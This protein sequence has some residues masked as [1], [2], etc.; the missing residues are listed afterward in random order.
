[1]IKEIYANIHNLVIL[2][3]RLFGHIL[4]LF[5]QKAELE[6][7]VSVLLS[8]YGGTTQGAGVGRKE[9]EA[10]RANMRMSY[11]IGCYYV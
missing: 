2:L 7:K 5:P 6:A 4:A 8:Y 11:P 10:G 3:P 9:S 1:M